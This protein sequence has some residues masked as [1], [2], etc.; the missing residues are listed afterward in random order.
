MA[1]TTDKPTTTTT[2]DKPT[3]RKPR[4]SY[5]LASKAD[6]HPLTLASE[7]VSRLS[8][9]DKALATRLATRVVAI[10]HDIVTDGDINLLNTL[11]SEATGE[12]RAVIVGLR[13]LALTIAG[14]HAYASRILPLWVASRDDVASARFQRASTAKTAKYE[15]IVTTTDGYKVHVTCNATASLDMR[16]IE[17][18]YDKRRENAKRRA[19]KRRETEAKRAKRRAETEAKRATAKHEREARREARKLM[20]ETIASATPAQLEKF[21]EMMAA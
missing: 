13:N 2:T 15:V 5:T 9:T 19:D 16:K 14:A 10:E 4:A 6:N 3:T 8:H 21:M 12:D 18:T 20:R 11:A 1:T 7:L 17:A